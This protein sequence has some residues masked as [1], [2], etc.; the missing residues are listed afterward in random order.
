MEEI[1]KKWEEILSYLKNEYAITDVSYDSWIKPLELFQIEDNKLYLTYSGDQNTMT[2]SYVTRKYATP[3]KV[4]IA[5]IT[6]IQFDEILVISQD[7]ANQIKKEKNVNINI[8]EAPTYN[9]K[10]IG[11]TTINPKF[12]FDNF[13]V[14]RNNRF[15]QTAALAVAESPGEFYNPLYIYGGPGLGK[16]HLMQ[17]IGNYIEN[18]N[19]NTH[20]LYVTSEEF[21]NEVIENM[22]ANSNATAMQRFRDKYRTVDV[23][24]VDDIQFIIGKEATQEEFFHTFNALHAMGKQIVISSDK[25]PKDMETLD[26]RF[27]SRFDMGLMADI[28]YPDYETRMAILN[29]KVEDKNFN[30]DESIRK[31][32]AENIQSNIREIE[33]AL[34]KL[35]AFS[36]LEKID[37]TMEIAERELQNFIS[38]NVSREITPQLIIEVVSE[39]FNLTVDQMASK[40]RSSNVARPRQIAMYLCNT[41]TDCSL[42]AIGSL[43]G[44]RD[45][46]TIIHGANK[47]GEEIEKDEN[48][49]N[50]VETIKKKINPN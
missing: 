28:G 18:Q 32:I 14:G 27:K 39:H 24:M 9:E 7:N 44:G 2:L 25:P 38:P 35:I 22:R 46:S 5:E 37:I 26:D 49:K 48:T 45:H 33:G 29:K 4:T 21:T 11:N 19:P 3:L 15:A 17:A 50:L 36:R 43:L 40:N 31:Y 47:I 8:E 16:T 13:V 34:N 6:G 1:V 42:Q 20:I 12:T 41:M 30:L 23:L 10:K